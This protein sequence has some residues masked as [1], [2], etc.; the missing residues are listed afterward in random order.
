MRYVY[1]IY[2]QPSPCF[3]RHREGAAAANKE[4]GLEPGLRPP[5]WGLAAAAA[6]ATTSAGWAGTLCPLGEV[7]VTDVY[8]SLCHCRR[9]NK[10]QKITS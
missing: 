1:Q 5:R 3:R 9:K 4:A 10:Q 8:L 6:A 2:V 7:L